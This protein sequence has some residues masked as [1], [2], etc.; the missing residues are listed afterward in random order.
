M[1]PFRSKLGAGQDTGGDKA[2][3]SDGRGLVSL[4]TGKKRRPK[5]AGEAV[6]INLRM[7]PATWTALGVLAAKQRRAKQDLLLEALDLVLVHYGEE[8]VNDPRRP[9]SRTSTSGGQ[10]ADP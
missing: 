4:Q 6:G 1:M 8:P 3:S 10:R 5:G 9:D 2:S 7:S